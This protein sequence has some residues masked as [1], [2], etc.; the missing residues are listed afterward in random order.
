MLELKS[1]PSI[2]HLCIKEPIRGNKK[3]VCV[4]C[5]KETQYGHK[6]D[7]S[8]NFTG[9]SY[10]QIG[11]TLC[12]HCYTFV[13]NQ[14]FRRKSWL[15]TEEGVVFLQRK[16]TLHYLLHPPNPPFAIYITLSGQ[17]QGWLNGYRQGVNFNTRRYYVMTDFASLVE[18]EQE[19]AQYL[20]ELISKL[21]EKKVTKQE[22]LSGMFSVSHHMQAYIEGWE[23]VF[24]EAQKYI[25]NPLWEVI[26]NVCE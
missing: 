15:A 26:V 6:S 22:L 3:G 8:D 20:Y 18:V 13:K 19:K 12:E 9:Y 11:S 4:L 21:R 14:D 17:R 16:E 1:V 23:D 5:G 25:K 2:A 24:L 7:F 10:L